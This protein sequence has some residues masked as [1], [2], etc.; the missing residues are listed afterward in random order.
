MD[1]VKS[2][3]RFDFN[4]NFVFDKNIDPIANIKSNIMINKWHR[5]LLNC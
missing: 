2:I 3:D 1:I 4:Y 5:F